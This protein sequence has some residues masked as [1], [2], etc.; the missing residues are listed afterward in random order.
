MTNAKSETWHWEPV[1]KDR[2]VLRRLPDLVETGSVIWFGG[3]KTL[4]D[5]VIADHEQARRVPELE[6]AL[7]DAD[8]LAS[9]V[10]QSQL[11]RPNT[12]GYDLD[13][14]VSYLTDFRQSQR[15]ALNPTPAA[16]SEADNG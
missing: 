4:R 13:D 16:E 3:N 8:D 11:L 15:A 9:V 6:R 12:E 7:E 14:V 5:E 1:G 10:E 2:I